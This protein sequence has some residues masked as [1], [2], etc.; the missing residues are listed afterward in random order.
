VFSGMQ[1]ESIKQD[2]KIQTK[3][4]YWNLL[5]SSLCRVSMI[6]LSHWI[7]TGLSQREE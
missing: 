3:E 7:Y 4:K 6:W 2:Q 5:K 1:N